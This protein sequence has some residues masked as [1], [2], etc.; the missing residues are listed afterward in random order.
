M[1]QIYTDYK[2][3][4]EAKEIEL[5]EIRFWYNPLIPNL[6]EAQKNAKKGGES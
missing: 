2:G 4:P 1:V 5:H 6:I 3:L